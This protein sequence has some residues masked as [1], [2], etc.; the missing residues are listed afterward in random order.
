MDSEGVE[1]NECNALETESGEWDVLGNLTPA[2]IT[3]AQ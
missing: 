3:C 2:E 1:G